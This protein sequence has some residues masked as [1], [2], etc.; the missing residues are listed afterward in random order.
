[1]TT[2]IADATLNA[3]KTGRKTKSSS[4]G[5][6]SGN[7]VCCPHNGE[8]VDKRGRGGVIISGGQVTYSCFN[9]GFKVSYKPGYV[10]SYKYK[11]LLK[12]MG[13]DENEIQRLN[14]E[15]LREKQR[16]EFLGIVDVEEVKEVLNVSFKPEPLPN[17]AVSILGL[18]EYHELQCTHDYPANMIQT[19]DYLYSRK[20]DMRKY[21][22]YVTQDDTFKMDQ[23]VIIPFTWENK[24]IGYTARAL[25]DTITPKYMG[26]IDSGY[27]FNVDKQER[28]WRF[29]ILCEGVLDAISIDA[30]S[31]QGASISKQQIDIIENLDR[32]IIVVPDWDKSGGKLIDIALANGWSVSFPVWAETVKDVNEAVMKYGK[33]FVLKTIL[34]SVESN[35]LKIKLLRRKYGG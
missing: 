19:V 26:K 30:V 14:I 9:C 22:F 35:S 17:E 6:I 10:L 12:W 5:W 18:V 4:H 25:T 29:V 24:I 2:L 15:A 16:Q 34:S 33:L 13:L 7:A 11:K 21:E 32:E 1:M 23:R 31:V 3:W 27:V 28:D 8:T 20:I